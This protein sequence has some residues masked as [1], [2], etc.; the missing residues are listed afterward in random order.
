MASALIAAVA[1]PCTD[2]LGQT[3]QSS[4]AE[5]VIAGLENERLAIPEPDE[6]AEFAERW[7]DIRDTATIAIDGKALEIVE[8]R[9]LDAD[10]IR[11]R[12]VT[13][14][15]KHRFKTFTS[16]KTF[17]SEF[18]VQAE[19]YRGALGDSAPGNQQLLLQLWAVGT[20]AA[21]SEQ[22][23]ICLVGIWCPGI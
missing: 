22:P 23:L 16:S 9:R 3:R 1:A 12:M 11:E 4:L 18:R 21:K 15:A 6:L 10:A 20:V 5:S 13:E 14:V 8:R 2:T 17:E 7:L 19:A